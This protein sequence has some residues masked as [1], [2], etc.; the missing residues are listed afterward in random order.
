MA[1]LGRRMLALLLVAASAGCTPAPASRDEVASPV[2]SSAPATSIQRSTASP[3][4]VPTSSSRRAPAVPSKAPSSAPPI[5]G[6]PAISAKARAAGLIDVR[7]IISDAI[8]DLR[9]AT[10]DNFVGVRL[11]PTDARC[12]VHQS[13]APGLRTAAARLR[14]QG[15]VLVFWDCYR[16]HAV[17]VHM[18]EVVPDPN[19]VARPGPFATSHEAARSVDVTLAQAA[20]SPG[21][22]AA[23]RVQ[24][25]CLL[26]MGTA[27]DDFSPRAQAFATSGVSA[28]AQSH[29]ARLRTA[30][31]AGGITVYSG[32]W[33]HFDGP[34]SAVKRPHLDAPLS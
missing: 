30:M 9:Y 20:T 1:A 17:Q 34:G 24:G 22:P 15:N 3:P 10:A 25:H 13:M 18:F 16:P 7:T 14:G 6:T 29:R 5:A 19:W 32:E 4:P 23:Q 26:D 27:F 8:V 33:W 21:C 11:Y 28:Q 2:P 31:N 12:L